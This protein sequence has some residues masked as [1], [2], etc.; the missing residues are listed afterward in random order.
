MEKIDILMILTTLGLVGYL[1]LTF[2]IQDI[3]SPL[4]TAY[5]WLLNI[6]LNMGYVGAF[7]VSL[8]GN[9]TVLVPFPYVGVPYILG[10]LRDPNTSQYIFDP[11][12]I[13]LVAGAGALIGE[14]TGYLAGYIGGTLIEEDHRTAFAK[15][16]EEHPRLTPLLL[17]FLAVTP[18]PDDVLIIPLGLSKYSWWKVVIPQFIGKMMFLTAIAWAGRLSLDLVDAFVTGTSSGGIVGR[19]IDTLSLFAVL[20]IIYIITKRNVGQNK[21]GDK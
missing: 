9:A 18:L 8:L 11:T 12:V 19:T 2:F 20:L 5:E 4:A 1:I 16:A 6:S 10:G 7:V 21:A 17:W 3:I 13:G 14:M 15:M